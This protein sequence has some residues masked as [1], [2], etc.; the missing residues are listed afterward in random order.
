MPA[1]DKPQEGGR[2]GR[3]AAASK[4]PAPRRCHGEQ[5][6][7][8]LSRRQ[9]IHSFATHL[10]PSTHDHGWPHVRRLWRR[11]SPDCDRT[12]YDAPLSYN[13][14]EAK[15]NVVH[16]DMLFQG[17]GEAFNVGAFLEA[18]SPYAWATTG[19]GLCIG[20]SVVGAAW[21]VP[22]VSAGGNLARYIQMKENKDELR[23]VEQ[24]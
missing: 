10:S 3:A 17:E 9:T 8:H 15:A 11:L 23:K 7:K 13:R 21:S 18:I 6:S 14:W 16:L 12:L 1:R 5:A 19:I 4:Q 24:I 2:A 20:L 22:T